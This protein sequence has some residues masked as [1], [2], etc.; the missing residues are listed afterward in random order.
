M[1]GFSKVL[2]CYCKVHYVYLLLPQYRAISV[3]QF[4]TNHFCQIVN[5]FMLVSLSICVHTMLRNEQVVGMLLKIFPEHIVWNWTCFMF[6]A[7]LAR[8]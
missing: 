8:T 7:W 1:K 2:I 3:K 4:N 6:A 5:N